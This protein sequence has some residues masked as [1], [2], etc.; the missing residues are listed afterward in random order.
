[1]CDGLSVYKKFSKKFNID[2]VIEMNNY[3]GIGICPRVFIHIVG[4]NS[5]FGP[6]RTNRPLT[7][8]NHGI[9]NKK[10][11]ID[12]YRKSYC[13]PDDLVNTRPNIQFSGLQAFSATR[14]LN[15]KYMEMFG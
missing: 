5:Y 12:Y 4:L 11:Y 9:G 14:K 1:M 10:Y 6:R 15:Q 2:D 7:T 8:T 13:C 3:V